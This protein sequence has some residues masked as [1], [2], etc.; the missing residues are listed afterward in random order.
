MN[1][2]NKEN[3]KTFTTEELG[4]KRLVAEGCSYIDITPFWIDSKESRRIQKIIEGESPHPED[5]IRKEA[6]KRK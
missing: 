6:D 2:E 3:I 5:L 4:L 1:K